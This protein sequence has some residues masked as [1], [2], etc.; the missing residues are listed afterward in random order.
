M[1]KIT[2]A[3]MQI[4]LTIMKIKHLSAGGR[5]DETVQRREKVSIESDGQL[6]HGLPPAFSIIP[7][8]WDNE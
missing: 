1:T 7:S 4:G 3:Q 2:R 6:Q 8:A 5:R